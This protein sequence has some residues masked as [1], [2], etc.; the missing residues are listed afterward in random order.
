MAERDEMPPD[1][2]DVFWQPLDATLRAVAE[3]CPAC[4]SLATRLKYLELRIDTRD[5]A[6]T[7]YAAHGMGGAARTPITAEDVRAAV[8]KCREL[9][10]HSLEPNGLLTLI[11]HAP[12][13][14]KAK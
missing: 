4:W 12:A 5:M 11:E 13:E 9:G 10:T 7:L 3:L 6:A 8:L 2:R 1:P 14:G